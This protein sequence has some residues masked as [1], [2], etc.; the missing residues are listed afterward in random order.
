M[1][2]VLAV[3]CTVPTRVVAANA[4]AGSS[5]N[6]TAQDASAPTTTIDN[7]FL[8]TK[9]DLSECLGRSVELPDCGIEPTN[10]GDRGGALQYTTF[11]LMVLGLTFIG[12][13]V[14]RA[15]RARDNALN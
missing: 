14:V 3:L 4:D 7:S 2:F 15:V 5:S 9:R 8:D 1:L 11:V 13:R 12:W 10:A 6:Q